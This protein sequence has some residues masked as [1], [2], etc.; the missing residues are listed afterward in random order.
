MEYIVGIDQGSSKTDVIVVNEKGRI[1]GRGR[2]GGGDHFL[3][4]MEHAM[5]KIKEALTMALRQASIQIEQISLL[6]SGLTGA[7]WPHEY[8]MLR[9]AL[10]KETGIKNVIVH[11]DCIPAMRSGLKT[12]YGVVL[13][14]GSGLNCAVKSPDGEEFVFGYYIDDEDQGGTAL[15]RRVLRSVFDAHSG[16]GASTTLI[17]RILEYFQMTDV[18]KLLESLVNSK[19]PNVKTKDLAPIAFEVAAEG[20][21][22]ALSLLK[23]F[24]YDMAKY[25]VAGLKKFNLLKL[26]LDVVL[27]G[28]I[29][30]CKVPILKE[31]VATF[32]HQYAPKVNIIEARFEPVV[33]A[34]LLGLDEYYSSP[35]PEEVMDNIDHDCRKMDL[36]R[37]GD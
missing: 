24:G 11:N 8:Q 21:L 28:G 37:G 9:E 33:G 32:I 6:T 36:L 35:L 17:S 19:I 2:S 26:E 16:V 25:V 7:D 29:F 31:A 22:V 3:N 14:A 13:C 18:D 10:T 20:D 4:G 30:K 12:S 34:A 23:K 1:F 15:G 5:G 27:S